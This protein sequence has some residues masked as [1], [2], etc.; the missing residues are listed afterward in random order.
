MRSD[1]F[2]SVSGI[3]SMKIK[4]TARSGEELLAIHPSS[5]SEEWF[6]AR[7]VVGVDGTEKWGEVG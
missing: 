4:K 1:A 2:A 7:Q 5:S 3:F 6:Y